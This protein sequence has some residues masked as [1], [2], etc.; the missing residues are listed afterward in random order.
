MATK[1]ISRPPM[2]EPVG[3]V[4]RRDFETVEEF[5]ARGGVIEYVPAGVSQ[6]SQEALCCP[7]LTRGRLSK[8]E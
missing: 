5:L 7:A 1:S 4:D 8:L 2:V 3:R 6:A